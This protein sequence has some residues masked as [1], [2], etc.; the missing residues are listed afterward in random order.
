MSK[1]RHSLQ[2]QAD[3][4]K[5]GS[6]RSV[7]IY[8]VILFA[9]AFVLL[10]LSYIMQQR[11]SE[12]TI[13]GLK[14]SVSAM[15]SA[16]D[17]YEENALLKQQLEQLE[18]QAETD[19]AERDR[20]Q[21][22]IQDLQQQVQELEYTAQAMDWFWQINEAYVRGRYTLARELIDQMGSE[23]PRYLPRESITD[24]ERFSPYDRYQ[25]IYDAL[26]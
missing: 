1:E 13:D 10:L 7:L 20:L 16:Q 4:A 9:V 14:Q 19:Q 21:Q 8:L 2:R 17:A 23:L 11:S 24:N 22:Q 25:E 18:Q 3:R 5:P 15:Q 12:E 6:R 26:N